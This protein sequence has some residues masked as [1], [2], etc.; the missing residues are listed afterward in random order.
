MTYTVSK[1]DGSRCTKRNTGWLT[2][3]W[4]VPAKIAAQTVRELQKMGYD[5][6]TGISIQRDDRA[7]EVKVQRA[8]R[9]ESFPLWG[10]QG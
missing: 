6:H 8:G 1:F 3:A 4:H 10:E 9:A 5:R 2:V 7:P